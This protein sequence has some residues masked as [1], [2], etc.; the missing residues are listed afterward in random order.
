VQEIDIKTGLVMF[1]WHAMGHVAIPDT[2]KRIPRLETTVLDFFHLNSI[3]PLPTG[4][5]LISS[6]NTWTTYL[7]SGTTGS[8]LWRLGGKK[9]NFTLGTGVSFAWQHDAQLLPD[10]T[11]SLFDNE[12]Y[13]AEASQSRVLDIA[14]DSAAHTAKLVHQL[15][16]PGEGILADSEGGAQLLANG[17]DFVGWGRTGEVS[18]L[19]SAGR[20]TFDMHLAPPAGTYRAFRV[21]WHGQPVTQPALAATQ[22]GHG[23]TQLYAS[24]NGATDVAA[25]RVLAG[26]SPT[27]LAAIGTYPTRGFETAIVAPT[28][29]PYIRVQ[30]LSATGSLLRSS[31]VTKS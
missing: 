22:T 4:D 6:R 19:S 10:G 18:E 14:L 12:S 21:Q 16:Y 3:D 1:E 26:A 31:R 8:V 25:W 2:Y 29:A 5:L 9:S 11:I 28:A 30:A 17:D 20:L 7:V 24:W 23:T 15:T 27:T 13:P